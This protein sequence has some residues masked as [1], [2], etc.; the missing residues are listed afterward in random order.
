MHRFLGTLVVCA[1]VLGPVV[2]LAERDRAQAPIPE[3]RGQIGEITTPHGGYC[4]GGPGEDSVLDPIQ[5]K[6]DEG[7]PLAAERE[8]VA[9]L[10]HGRVLRWERA[11]AFEMLAEL[12]VRLGEF[13]RA[14]INYRT[15]RSIRQADGEEEPNV[16]YAVALFRTGRVGAARREARAFREWACSP[17][18]QGDP[19]CYG[20]ALI[21]LATAPTARAWR[22]AIE[23]ASQIS[24]GADSEAVAGL[25]AMRRH[26]PGLRVAVAPPRLAVLLRANLR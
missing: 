18:P 5:E 26:F 1:V 20:A 4:G 14:V 7:R 9:A 11:R 13:E 12:Q 15:A 17:D 24:A 23:Q 25:R 6:I 2:G 3:P 16:G 22:E 21:L 10:R 8:L 19:A